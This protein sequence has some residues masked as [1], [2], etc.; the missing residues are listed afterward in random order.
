[1]KE[2]AGRGKNY[3][4]DSDTLNLTRCGAHLRDVPLSCLLQ[5]Q[6]SW[7]PMRLAE[8]SGK[9]LEEWCILQIDLADFTPAAECIETPIVG[10]V[11]LSTASMPSPQ[12][13]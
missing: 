3:A 2:N 10:L 5:R 9:S 1:M 11:S 12:N 6:L 4:S 13:D 7:E 8:L